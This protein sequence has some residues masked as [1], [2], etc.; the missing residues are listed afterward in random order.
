LDILCHHKKIIKNQIRKSFGQIINSVYPF[1]VEIK[2][3][4]MKGGMALLI[5]GII[6][7]ISGI[8]FH[9]Q[10]QSIVGP[11][12]SF[13]YSNPDWITYGLEIVIIGAIISSIGFVIIRKN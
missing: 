4:D 1:L 5:I 10:G 6:I 9:L 3:K 7:G 8:I 2:K 11:E 12:E 13:M